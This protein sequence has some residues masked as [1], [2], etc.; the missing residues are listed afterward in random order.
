M[1]ILNA[2]RAGD[3][4][5]VV[6]VNKQTTTLTADGG[7]SKN[8]VAVAVGVR[9]NIRPLRGR[10][11]FAA[12]QVKADAEFKILLRYDSRFATWDSNYQVVWGSR[13]FEAVGP[14]KNVDERNVTLEAL[15]KETE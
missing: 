3:F 2:V 6:T 10:E 8:V 12:Q 15:A 5:H 13:T 7:W 14:I 9:A 4:P 11:L 1:G